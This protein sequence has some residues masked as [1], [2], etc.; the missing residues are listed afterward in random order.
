MMSHHSHNYIITQ[1]AMSQSQVGLR[2]DGST[3]SS[4]YLPRWGPGKLL[5]KKRETLQNVLP[6]LDA[7]M[8]A[9]HSDYE[10]TLVIGQEQD[11]EGGD[12][13]LE[14]AQVPDSNQ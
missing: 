2:Q 1:L 9:N 12:A 5:I 6:F 7:W 13:D 14:R 8:Y 10:A 11:V 3:H 4:G